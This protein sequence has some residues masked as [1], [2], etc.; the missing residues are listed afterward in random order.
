MAEQNS[1]KLHIAMYPWLAT[2]HATPFLYLSNEL[3]KRGHKITF[4][5]PKKGQLQLQHLNHFPKLITFN[6]VQIPHVEGLPLDTETA[7]EIPISL[8]HLLVIGMNRT[9][10]Q[11]EKALSAMKPDIVLYDTAHWLP[12]IARRFGIKTVCYNVVCAASLAIALVPARN[13]PKDRPITVEELSQ[14]PPGYPSPKL[15]LRGHEAKTLLFLSMPWGEGLTFYESITTAMKESDAIAIRTSKEI[16]ESLC[17]YISSQYKKPVLLTGPVLPKESN[18]EKLEEPWCKWLDE[19]RQG[20][21]IFC[22]FGSQIM[23]E[24]SQFQELLLGFEITGLPFLV[25]LKTPQGCE[26]I[27]E[28]LPEGFEERVKGRGVVSKGWV[29]QP[30]ILNHSSVGCFVNHCGFGSMW[31]SLMSD[32]Q[33]VLIPH[34]GDQLLSTKLLVEELEVAVEVKRGENNWVS[35]ENLSESIKLVMDKDSEVGDRLKKNHKKWMDVLAKPGFMDG[36]IDSFVQ[37][38]QQLRKK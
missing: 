37:S 4:F 2:G 38:L 25:S 36:Y 11:V 23:L 14:P 19:F 17:D 29:Q 10:D 34:L 21:V 6:I 27:E 32:K 24:K 7:S 5:I 3:A 18:Q 22:A 16:E 33:I 26:T 35:K 8:N 28:A 9:C 15:V 1:S 31:E 12:Q 30:L 13:F 20:S